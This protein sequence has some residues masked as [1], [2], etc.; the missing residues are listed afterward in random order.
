MALQ[1]LIPYPLYSPLCIRL[2]LNLYFYLNLHTWTPSHTSDCSLGI[3]I[4]LSHRYIY[5]S[6]IRE[7]CIFSPNLTPQ[8]CCFAFFTEWYYYLTH[9]IY[10]KYGWRGYWFFLLHSTHLINHQLLWSLTQKYFKIYSCPFLSL[11]IPQTELHHFFT[12]T[13]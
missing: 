1:S 12:V 3:L 7:K 2:F 5:F 11:L 13:L 10:Q 4:L 6:K 8:M 9:S